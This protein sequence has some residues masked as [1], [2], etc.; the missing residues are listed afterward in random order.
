MPLYFTALIAGLTALLDQISKHFLKDASSVLLPGLIHLR[1]V[2][3]TGAAFSLFSQLPWLIPLL[4]AALTAGLVWYMLRK[5]PKGLM[6]VGLALLLGGAA[7]NLID[8]L[9]LGYV[10]D[11]I[12]LSFIPFPIFNLADVAVVAGCG[13]LTLSI[14]FSREA[15]HA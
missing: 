3:N 9:R 12:E 15:A 2:R 5:R 4:S 6:G 1:G 7:G 13:L 14:L 11:F 10:V 8:R